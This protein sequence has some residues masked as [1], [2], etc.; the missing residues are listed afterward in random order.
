MTAEYVRSTYRVPAK[1]GGRVL[2]H[3]G[4]GVIRSFDSM[5]RVTLSRDSRRTYRMHPTW[6]M[7]YL[8]DAGAV[9][10][11]AACDRCALVEASWFAR[12][13]ERPDAPTVDSV[14]A[15]LGVARWEA[16]WV[17]TA[18]RAHCAATAAAA[19]AD[20]EVTASKPVTWHEVACPSCEA[21]DVSCPHC[22]AR[23]GDGC[24]TPLGRLRMTPHVR[25]VRYAATQE[26]HPT[27]GLNARPQV[28]PVA[29][30]VAP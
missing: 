18:W 2:T 30:D 23:S 19:Q 11:G 5:L 4:P 6:C 20:T 16:Q 21:I 10:E 3:D 15:C 7:R 8:D 9:I 13:G 25:R 22:E 28:E 24:R 14:Q 1:R 26:R 12:L 29:E 27:Y 17:M